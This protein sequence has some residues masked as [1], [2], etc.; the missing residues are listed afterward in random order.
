MRRYNS[1]FI[2]ENGIDGWYKDVLDFALPSTT[3]TL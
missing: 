2:S 1:K 3:K